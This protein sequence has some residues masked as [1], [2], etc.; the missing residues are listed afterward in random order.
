MFNVIFKN[1]DFIIQL[2]IVFSIRY[3][4]I[5]KFIVI[6]KNYIWIIL[7]IKMKMSE[8][9]NSR[10]SKKYVFSR[11]MCNSL[12]R[13]HFSQK[14]NIFPFYLLFNFKVFFYLYIFIV[15]WFFF[16]FFSEKLIIKVL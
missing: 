13:I 10:K 12:L 16:F 14:N 4:L 7:F 6:Y 15:F 5:V 1:I 11:N 2:K 9:K 8:C 3:Y